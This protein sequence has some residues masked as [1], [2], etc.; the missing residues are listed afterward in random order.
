MMKKKLRKVVCGA[1]IA[2]SLL[3]ISAMAESDGSGNYSFNVGTGETKRG[4]EYVIKRTTKSYAQIST[5]SFT[6]DGAYLQVRNDSENVV[7]NEVLVGGIGNKNI[8][9]KTQALTGKRYRLWARSAST[10]A[11]RVT[12]LAG[13]WIP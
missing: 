4:Q 3:G 6:G 2:T 7:S 5:T 10:G 13:A 11:Y 9:Y 8:S 1:L 12:Y